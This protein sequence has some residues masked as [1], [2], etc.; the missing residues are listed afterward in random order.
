VV[1]IYDVSGRLVR[2]LEDR[3]LWGEV[4]ERRW[5][6]TDDAG[7]RVGSGVYFVQMRIG[8]TVARQKLIVV[9]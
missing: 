3:E 9:R 2:A 5:D 6:G 1:G 8:S 7:T 4:T